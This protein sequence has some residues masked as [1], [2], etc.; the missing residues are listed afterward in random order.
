M[1]YFDNVATTKPAAAQASS[2][3]DQW[4]HDVLPTPGTQRNQALEQWAGAPQGTTA[5]PREEHLIPLHVA[6][7]AAADD[8]GRAFFTGT[9][10]G[11]SMSCWVFGADA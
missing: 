3:F 10:L 4:L 11:A 6:A 2:E 7:G 9:A 8:P 5:H 1:I